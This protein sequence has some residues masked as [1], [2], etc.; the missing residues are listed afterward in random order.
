MSIRKRVVAALED[1]GR[2]EATQIHA[3]AACAGLTLFQ[4]QSCLYNMRSDKRGVES[5]GPQQKRSGKGGSAP[6]TYWLKSMPQFRPETPEQDKRERAEVLKRE[7]AAKPRQAFPSVFHY[8]LG[9]VV[10]VG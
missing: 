7:E 4:V 6:T 3:H 1:L 5:A 8:G 9:E 10:N 2:A